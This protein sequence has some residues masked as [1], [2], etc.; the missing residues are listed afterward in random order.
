MSLRFHHVFFLLMLFALISAFTLSP[1]RSAKLTPQIQT[2]FAPISKPSASLGRSIERRWN[3]QDV[4]DP[5]SS[6]VIAAEN[7]ELR[8]LNASLKAQLEDLKILNADREQLG[9]VRKQSRIYNVIAGDSASREMI[10]IGGSTLEGLE[11][12]QPVVFIGGLVG[13]VTQVGVAGAKIQ[14]ITDVGATPLTGVIGRFQ[15]GEDGRAEFVHV[16]LSTAN[17]LVEGAGSN[18]MVI[19]KLTMK[20]AEPIQ[21][22]DWV[23]L[24]DTTWPA[25]VQEYKIGYV[26]SKTPRP[27]APLHAKIT[28]KPSQNLKGLQNVSVVVVK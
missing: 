27:D 14:L 7:E 21:V 3:R 16:K 26:A 4:V 10:Q 28:I 2:L 25:N 19:N 6:A 24:A 22:N 5:R 8:V 20:E 9:D 13:R 11:L 1:E 18:T 15:K 17:V 12:N 23:V